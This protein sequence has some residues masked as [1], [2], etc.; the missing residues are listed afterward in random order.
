M[1]CSENGRDLFQ[2]NL[3]SLLYG[4]LRGLWTKEKYFGK[5]ETS[6]CMK[7]EKRLWIPSDDVGACQKS[8]KIYWIPLCLA[9]WNLLQIECSSDRII[10]KQHSFS[11]SHLSTNKSANLPIRQ[12]IAGQ[13]R[14]RLL[15]VLNDAH[16]LIN[17]P[18]VQIPDPRKQNILLPGKIVKKIYKPLYSD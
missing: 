8:Q 2:A 13:H 16:N 9:I 11:Y 5:H 10:W 1:T 6:L 4:K 3:D 14:V 7:R 18:T 17:N 15:L 12:A